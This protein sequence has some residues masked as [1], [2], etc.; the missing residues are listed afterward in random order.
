MHVGTERHLKVTRATKPLVVVVTEIVG[1][2]GFWV[3]GCEDTTTVGR[4]RAQGLRHWHEVSVE[5]R[6]RGHNGIGDG[7]G[8]SGSSRCSGDLAP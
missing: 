2:V 7:S 5:R 3:V 4:P 1:S 8:S 6:R